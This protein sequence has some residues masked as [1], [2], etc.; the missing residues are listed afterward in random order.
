MSPKTARMVVGSDGSMPNSRPRIERGVLSA[1]DLNA[2]K[3]QGAVGEICGR[4][5][6]RHGR[7][8]DSPWRD[9]VLSISLEQLRQIPQVVG[10]VAGA[11]RSEALAAAIRGRLVKS[12][13]I[14]E[15]GAGALLEQVTAA[16][17][18]SNGQQHI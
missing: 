8:C 11:D 7:E 15:E 12:L 16:S 13:L 18:S 10:I 6:D 3:Q 14:D 5:F 17:T 1:G 9:R 4:F 2:L